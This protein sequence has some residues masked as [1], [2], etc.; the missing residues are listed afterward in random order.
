MI[1]ATGTNIGLEVAQSPANGT[2]QAKLGYNRA[3]IALVRPDKYEDGDGST[4]LANVL[5][6]LHYTNMF[7][8]ENASIYQRTAIGKTAVQSGAATALL[9]RSANGELDEETI[10]ALQALE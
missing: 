8:T 5:R 9:A 3:E 4:D 10:A 7:S 1:A 2:P 6:E